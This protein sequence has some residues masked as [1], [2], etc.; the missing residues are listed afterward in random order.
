MTLRSLV[1]GFLMLTA[2]TTLAAPVHPPLEALRRSKAVVVRAEVAA[3]DV[4][5]V[6][7]D[8]AIRE[9]LAGEG[10]ERITL[11]V[12]RGLLGDIAVG[13]RMI[14]AYGDRR[15][16]ARKPGVQVQTETGTLLSPEGLEPA[17]LR[18]DPDLAARFRPEH[19]DL[20]ASAEWRI[21][22]TSGL[23]DAD[24][25]A[26]NFFAAELALRPLWMRE[27]QPAEREAA[28]AL[29]RNVDAHPAAR[30]RLLIAAAKVA[31][32]WG[33]EALAETARAILA[34]SPV[35]GH[36]ADALANPDTAVYAALDTLELLGQPADPQL[37]QRWLVHPSPHLVERVLLTLRNHDADLER[38]ALDQLS[39]RQRL[40]IT[41]RR[42]L[43]DHRRRLPAPSL[44]PRETSTP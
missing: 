39:A 1:L 6:T 19:A 10:R 26:H 24:P 12:P 8:L 7:V 38:S 16:V 2:G 17:W 22:V 20:E 30:A 35:Q 23:H 43:D 3:L 29:M 27:P 44:P 25:D 5:A 9:V 31:P 34:H 18:D 21:R 14:V 28:L 4:T 32:A 42:F 36:C 15:K 41:M 11:S 33:S 13:D 37:L 40:P